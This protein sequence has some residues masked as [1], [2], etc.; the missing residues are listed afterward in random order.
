MRITSPIYSIA[1]LGMQ[2]HQFHSIK[3]DFL[4]SIAPPI[5]SQL[6]SE[7][8]HSTSQ[9]LG[10]TMLCFHELGLQAMLRYSNLKFLTI[11]VVAD[12]HTETADRHIERTG[13]E[14]SKTL[15]MN[16]SRTDR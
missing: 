6:T 10:T 9:S 5:M 12:H 7:V 2:H 11:S 15:K 3:T 16:I 13:L 1:P 4:T 14:E 8:S